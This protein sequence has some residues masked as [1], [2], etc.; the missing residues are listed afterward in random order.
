MQNAALPSAHALHKA[1]RQAGRQACLLADGAYLT[2]DGAVAQRL[3]CPAVCGARLHP[4]AGLVQAMQQPVCKHHGCIHLS[5]QALEPTVREWHVQ[6]THA[7][8]RRLLDT[9]PPRARALRSLQVTANVMELHI[10]R[11]QC[12]AHDRAGDQV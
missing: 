6:Q 10:S 12:P 2:D 5:M 1:S 11:R 8:T 4:S 9:R 3:P 7:C